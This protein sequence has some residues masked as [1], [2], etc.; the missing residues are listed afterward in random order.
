M[1]Q[2]KFSMNCW[3]LG[4]KA[5]WGQ[6]LLPGGPWSRSFTVNCKRKKL[7]RLSS[8]SPWVRHGMKGGLRFWHIHALQG[9]T[10]SGPVRGRGPVRAPNV[11]SCPGRCLLG[12]KAR[13]VLTLMAFSV[14][15]STKMK[16][17]SGAFRD[18]IKQRMVPIRNRQ[19]IRDTAVQHN[20][21]S[22]VFFS[23]AKG[24]VRPSK[25]G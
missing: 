16:V 13:L 10:W 24:W 4:G 21:P 8:N 11:L 20:T 7:S 2:P 1:L 18:L 17:Y 19:E 5:H 25:R 3:A 12:N 14:F 22:S 15:L 6:G 23:P 9:R